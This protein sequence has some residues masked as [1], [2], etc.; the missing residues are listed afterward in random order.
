[1]TDPV[2]LLRESTQLGGKATLTLKLRDTTV[3]DVHMLRFFH[4][5]PE[6]EVSEITPGDADLTS[7][8]ESGG[9]GVR[10]SIR[11]FGTYVV[12]REER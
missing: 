8:P 12:V 2:A 9:V 5:A 7:F 1:M 4:R 6:G 11:R 10:F 3:D